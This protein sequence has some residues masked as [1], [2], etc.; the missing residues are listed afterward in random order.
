MSF[1]SL[2]SD[3]FARREHC[4]IS[5]NPLETIID[6]GQQSLTGVF[7]KSPTVPVD[8]SPLELAWC[9]QSGLVQLAHDYPGELMY[10]ETYGYRSGLN[11]SMVRHLK[12]KVSLLE[13][14]LRP[15]SP[16]D[17]VLD[18][19]S[20]DGTTLKAF[21]SPGITKVGI[22]PSAGKFRNFYTD[23]ILLDVDFFS[24]ESYSRLASKPARI[25]TSIAMFYDLPEPVEFVKQVAS[26][27][28]KDGIW[29]LEQSYLPLMLS[30][31]SYDTICQE[32]LE[33]YSLSVVKAILEQAD[34]KIVDVTTNGVNGGSFAVTAMHKAATPP[35]DGI[36]SVEDMLSY[37]HDID[38]ASGA[39]YKAFAQ[40]TR[41]HAKALK[42]LLVGL[43]ASGKRV[44][45][46]GAST[47]GNVLLQY[48]GIGPELLDGIS[49]VN[50][51]KWG[52]VTP[53]THIPIMSEQDA[54]AMKPDY[55]L[56]LPWHF[57][58]GIIERESAFLASGGK[59]L[60]PL[61]NI[62]ICSADGVEN[63]F[64]RAVEIK[65]HPPIEPFVSKRNPADNQLNINKAS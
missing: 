13:N 64:G 8:V 50:P 3:K 19:G 60:F 14:K 45:G 24:E 57:K 41:F 18:I 1:T 54:R 36:W 29:H 59:L 15:L 56:V 16:G 23:D 32:H 27:L 52:C 65:S 6:L 25:I 31:N 10:G 20:N 12:E 62:E 37:E 44:F 53:G 28:A 63:P 51:D 40:R 42:D 26:V 46:L 47:K 30:Q 55:F 4:R 58:T 38:L 11:A 2:P 17:V 22:D 34:L 43:K 33:Y 35:F 9:R 7:P 21:Q 61:P 49:D 39:P 5:K 48:S